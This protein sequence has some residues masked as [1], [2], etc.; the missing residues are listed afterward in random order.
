MPR[1]SIDSGAFDFHAP[2]VSV[3]DGRPVA[4]LL[5]V[6]KKRSENI[7]LIPLNRVSFETDGTL[8]NG[9]GFSEEGFNRT[10]KL[11]GLPRRVVDRLMETDGRD[12]AVS[13]VRHM[14]RATESNLVLTTLNGVVEGA[15][16][17]AQPP[18]DSHDALSRLSAAIDR[19]SL[20]I[21]KLRVARARLV[22][23]ST[24]VS[25]VSEAPRELVLPGDMIRAGVELSH[26]EG[27]LIDGR[28]AGFLYRLVCSN[29]AVA[30][31][32]EDSGS[33]GH[34]DGADEALQKQIENAV[35]ASIELLRKVHPA[36][37]VSLD[38]AN[39]HY[40]FLRMAEK[41]GKENANRALAH[42]DAEAS[43]YKRPTA[44][45]YDL[46]NGV[47]DT[48]KGAASPTRRWA[49]ESYSA[50][51]LDWGASRFERVS[52]N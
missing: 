27:G 13:A 28:V 10:L 9:M 42:A 36:S 29:G 34:G 8:D 35:N 51:I 3:L 25:L 17:N 20:P 31:L 23:L 18:I 37:K 40:H 46:W 15:I 26:N 22:G 44:T 24:D 19:A 30:R 52:K 1:Y 16:D 7:E 49:M 48:A 14:M 2:A 11:V 43:R 41:F 12:I 6:V 45:A 5:D 39:R 32:G 33:F 47:T 21:D 50:D 4:D 38:N